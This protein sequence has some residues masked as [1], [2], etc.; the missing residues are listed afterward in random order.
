[1]DCEPP[2]VRIAIGCTADDRSDGRS[3][4]RIAVPAASIALNSST[5]QSIAM[6]SVR[7]R[8]YGMITFWRTTVS[9][10]RPVDDCGGN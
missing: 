8:L 1:V 2:E 10:S 5:R 6:A 7:G 9:V 3:P 4:V